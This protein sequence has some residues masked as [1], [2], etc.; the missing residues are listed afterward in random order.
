MDRKKKA[1][2]AAIVLAAGQSRRMGQPK[3]ILPWGETTVIGQVVITLHEAGLAPILAVTGGARQQVESALH[4]LPAKPVFNP[5]YEQDHMAASLKIGLKNL[6]RETEAV[7]V[8]LGDQPQI[9]R[10]VVD[11]L[12]SA[13]RK[14]HASLVVPSYRM[15]RGHPWIIAHSLWRQVLDL[16]AGQTLRDFMNACTSQIHYVRTNTDSILRDLDTPEQYLH[17]QSR[18]EEGRD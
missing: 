12:L 14:Q 18:I 1:I 8:A 3:M 13:Y 4:T 15:R 16:T 7:M 2:I 6:P 11:A 10:R 17:E 5:D 9:E